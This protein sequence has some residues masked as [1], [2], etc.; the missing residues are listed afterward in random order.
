MTGADTSVGFTSTE[1][2]ST[3]ECRL[4]GASQW[5]ACTSP[6]ALG[7]LA[8]GSHTFRVR[9]QDAAGNTDATPAEHTWTVDTDPP[10]TTIESGPSGLVAS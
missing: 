9:A 2:G 6:R 5:T 3:F 10:G 1:P 4:D 7:G 8:S